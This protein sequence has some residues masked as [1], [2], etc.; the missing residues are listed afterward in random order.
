MNLEFIAALKTDEHSISNL[1][2]EIP[3][4]I[5]FALSN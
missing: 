4:D 5:C 1:N 2:V 3:F